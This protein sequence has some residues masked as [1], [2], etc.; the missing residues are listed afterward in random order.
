MNLKLKRLVR[1]AYSEQYALFDLDQPD[2]AGAPRTVGKLDLHYTNEGMYGTLLLW[3]AS[4]RTLRPRTRRAFVHALL[5]EIAQPM[6]VPN[7]YVVE[8]FA[9][10]LDQ[11]EVFHNVTLDEESV[12]DDEAFDVVAVDEDDLGD[13][14]LAGDD[15]ADGEPAGD[16][17]EVEPMPPS[18]SEPPPARRFAPRPR[19]AS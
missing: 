7:E 1:T 5:R 13:E 18:M 10:S 4:M 11:Y 19:D 15:D 17:E 6:G 16:A 2:E 8:F 12:E 3:D 14:S 9:P